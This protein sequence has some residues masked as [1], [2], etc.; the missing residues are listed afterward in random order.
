[1]AVVRGVFDEYAFTWEAEGYH[2]DLYDLRA[3]YFERG[4][5]FF[6]AEVEAIE[7]DVEQ[8]IIGTS[9]LKLF[10][11]IPGFTG[12]TIQIEG[13]TRLCGTDCSL[14][15]LYVLPSARRLGIGNALTQAVIEGAKESGRGLME[16]WSDK[17]FVEAHRLYQ[18]FG[19]ETIAERVLDDPD[20]SP[21]WG[22]ILRLESAKSLS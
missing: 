13:R 4:H 7:G 21:E 16:I 6:V 20:M 1:M 3:H 19:A 2:G 14:D 17:R 18:R 10:E 11:T 8:R 15:R 9:A 12:Q 5:S 22:L